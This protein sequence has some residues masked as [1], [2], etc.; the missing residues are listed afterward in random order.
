MIILGAVL[1]LL[2]LLVPVLHVLFWIGVIVLGVG[3][4][5]VLVGQSGRSVGG[6]RYWY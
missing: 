1:V 3:L 2:A 4:V 6:R 5:L